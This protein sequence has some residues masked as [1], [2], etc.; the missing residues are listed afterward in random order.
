[1]LDL[2]E[3][4]IVDNGTGLLIFQYRNRQPQMDA[5]GAVCGFGDWGKWK[6]VPTVRMF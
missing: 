4:R 6:A 3:L 5:S 2:I 1:M